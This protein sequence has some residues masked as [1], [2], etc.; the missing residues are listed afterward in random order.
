MPSHQWYSKNKQLKKGYKKFPLLDFE[1]RGFKLAGF[2]FRKSENG[3]TVNPRIY[4]N[5]SRASHT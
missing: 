5:R 1:F 2:S 4:C 3:L